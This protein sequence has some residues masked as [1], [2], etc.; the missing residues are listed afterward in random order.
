MWV[1]LVTWLVLCTILYMCVRET[2][3]PI[4]IGKRIVYVKPSTHEREEETANMLHTMIQNAEH[5]QK[6]ME[7]DPKL[8]EIANVLK[9]R[10]KHINIGET[11]D[12]DQNIAYSI[13]KNKVRLCL[14]NADGKL[15]SQQATIF[16]F[17]HELAHMVSKS[18]GH[19]SEFHANLRDLTAIARKE[20]ILQDYTFS[21]VCGTPIRH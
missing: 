9:K 12:Q 10:L 4:R 5:I 2:N 6:S 13:N 17:L 8:R 3:K 20:N 16:I 15:A 1:I 21:D 19:T 11:Y 18:T 14:R 7:K